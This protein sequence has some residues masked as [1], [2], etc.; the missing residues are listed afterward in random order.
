VLDLY[1]KALPMRLL[2]R[3]GPAIIAV[4]AAALILVGA[5]FGWQIITA[6]P[7]ADGKQPQKAAEV[8]QG[9]KR[10]FA[11]AVEEMQKQVVE[12]SKDQ[13]SIVQIHVKAS[14]SSGVGWE[15]RTSE[16]I[17]GER[18]EHYS[19]DWPA[20]QPLLAQIA[21]SGP[22]TI[23][24][25]I[26][27]LSPNAATRLEANQ[28]V[29]ECKRAGFSTVDYQGPALF[30]GG[31]ADPW[32]ADVFNAPIFH[33]RIDLKRGAE[34]LP[35]WTNGWAVQGNTFI[36][37]DETRAKL[38]AIETAQRIGGAKGPAAMMVEQHNAA[39]ERQ[40]SMPIDKPASPLTEIAKQIDAHQR[41]EIG[42]QATIRV[43]MNPNYQP[44]LDIRQKFPRGEATTLTSGVKA[45]AT[46][47]TRVAKV[48]TRME[49]RVGT[50]DDKNVA[51]Q[52]QLVDPLA[53]NAVLNACR[54]S[55]IEEISYWGQK[56]ITGSEESYTFLNYSGQTDSLPI[57]KIVM[58]L[59]NMEGDLPEEANGWA[60]V[61]MPT[62]TYVVKAKDRERLVES[63]TMKR[64]DVR[65]DQEVQRLAKLPLDELEKELAKKPSLLRDRW[66]KSVEEVKAKLK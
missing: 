28:L 9:E 19:T 3:F 35:D 38:L 22:K 59:R 39:R 49:V 12:R 25:S 20:I 56:I 58:P 26:E 42:N 57:L 15:I 7:P 1:R 14:I 63:L 34:F 8:P 45:Y 23:T 43:V 6:Q 46:L 54:R 62:H 47:V 55:G 4:V 44:V 29:N 16:A 51:L 36:K 64:G 61:R 5:N 24:A 53:V 33:H 52:T 31:A 41:L 30:L 37:L 65:H 2:D 18:V 27:A 32:K 10:S 21:A 48:G 66:R 40:K 17:H 13:T 11:A 50:V 60:T